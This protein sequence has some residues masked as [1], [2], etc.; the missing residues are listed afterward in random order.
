MC[1]THKSQQQKPR[2]KKKNK[3]N[4]GATSTQHS[5]ASLPLSLSAPLPCT[6]SLSFICKENIYVKFILEKIAFSFAVHISFCRSFCQRRHICLQA[7]TF[8]VSVVVAHVLAL[9]SLNMFSFICQLQHLSSSFLMSSFHT[10]NLC[11]LFMLF[12]RTIRV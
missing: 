3:C 1:S 8:V 11:F 5:V 2:K 10:G 7:D 6:A 12:K 9:P 4:I